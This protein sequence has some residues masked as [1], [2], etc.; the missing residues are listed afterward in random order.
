MGSPT[1]PLVSVV[2]PALNAEATLAKTLDSVIRQTLDDWECLVVDDGSSD[3]TA[4]LAAAIAAREPRIRLIRQQN[5]GV[6]AAR[7]TSIR[8]SRGR[9]IAPL[10]ADDLW[11]PDKLRRQVERIEAEGADCGLV[12]CWSRK[13]DIAGNR[14]W[15]CHPFRVEGSAYHI[16]VM[17][18][19]V[20]NASVPLFRRS[21]IERV[22]DYLTREEQSGAQGCEDWDLS[23]RVLDAYR[24]AVV[25]EYLVSY[26]EVDRCMSRNAVGMASSYEA[27][28]RRVLAGKRRVAPAILRWSR[29][30]FYAY[31]MAKAYLGGDHYHTLCYIGRSVRAD[32]LMCLNRRIYRLGSRAAIKVILRRD[33]PV[34]LSPAP[35]RRAAGE[36]SVRP[37]G[38]SLVDLVEMRRWSLACGWPADGA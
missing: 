19:F 18:N 36:V 31:L 37:R 35:R 26:R 7:N 12:Y 34:V 24:C 20:G 8:A 22:G 1:Q 11:E 17:R 15:D 29:G 28:I 14:L 25:P 5:A 33:E 4:E 38:L 30:H 10:D 13:I 27:V 2:V 32:P 9:Y 16:L 3:G 6:G 21:S 23:L